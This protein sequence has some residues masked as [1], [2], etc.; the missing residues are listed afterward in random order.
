MLLWLCIFLKVLLAEN[1]PSR[2]LWYQLHFSV[3]SE[4]DTVSVSILAPKRMIIWG[5]LI[6]D[7][8]IRNKNYPILDTIKETFVQQTIKYLQVSLLFETNSGWSCVLFRQVMC[9][10]VDDVHIPRLVHFSTVLL[11][12]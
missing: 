5:S 3:R 9:S 1:R 2:L 4:N 12:K 8:S 10:V 6:E 11:A 7:V